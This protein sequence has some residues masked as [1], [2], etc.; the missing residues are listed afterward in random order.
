MKPMTLGLLVTYHD[1]MDEL[2]TQI[3]ECEQD[4]NT[5]NYKKSKELLKK[6]H[7]METIVSPY[8]KY[9]EMNLEEFSSAFCRIASRFEYD[10]KFGSRVKPVTCTEGKDYTGAP[11]YDYTIPIE[12]YVTIR[13]DSADNSEKQKKNHKI[14]IIS[15][16]FYLRTNSQGESVEDR[17]AE[18]Q[19]DTMLDE[20]LQNVK[21]NLLTNKDLHLWSHTNYSDEYN[22]PNLD[23]MLWEAF[24][25]YIEGQ[26]DKCSLEILDKQHE[27]ENQSI[28]L[29]AQ[30]L[31]CLE[32]CVTFNTADIQ[33]F[34]QER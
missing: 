8:N 33:D 20:R 29:G 24:Q 21:I 19:E 16:N 27:L 23:L 34:Q 13:N 3:K 26:F 12:Y 25:S 31:D 11:I 4:P 5:E 1:E 30:A 10:A 14:K 28:A 32:G 9:F 18:I 6:Y 7:E 2:K 17:I 22:I 15:S